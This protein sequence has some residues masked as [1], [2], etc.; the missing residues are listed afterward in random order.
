[1]RPGCGIA[2]SG[3]SALRHGRVTWP[4]PIRFRTT[5]ATCLLAET[6]ELRFLRSV[7]WTLGTHRQGHT[8]IVEGLRTEVG[9][10]A[11]LP[12]APLF[13]LITPLWNTPPR[14]LHELI[15]S[16]RCQSWL[17]WEL[18]LVDD[19]SVRCDHLD[20]AR[21]WAA[22]DP[23]IHLAMRGANGGI[24][25]ARNEAIAL[26]SGDFLAVLYHDDLLH[27]LALS[28]FVRQL[29]GRP[30][31]NLLYSN[32]AKI[33]EASDEVGF[34]LNKPPFDLSTLLR[35]NYLCHFTAV[36]R[37]LVLAVARDGLVFRPQFDGADD[38]DLFL[39]M[40][41]TGRVRPVHVPMCLYYWRMIATSTA[42]SEETKPDLDGKRQAMLA[43][44]L[45]KIYSWCRLAAPVPSAELGNQ[46]TSI[47]ITTLEA[48]PRPKLLV[49]VPF[50][51]NLRSPSAA[52]NPSRARSTGSTWR[53]S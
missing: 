35:V 25:A 27:P 6:E 47:R 1:M 52:S 11:E 7:P 43:D 41:L 48:H 39:R 53:L 13:S 50:R 38:H 28:T 51:D 34:Y 33:N 46:Y 9:R 5:S 22:R 3:W 23:R 18:I 45:P 49:M 2:T 30:D 37:D 10:L 36:R 16:V 20:V 40:A 31:V 44:L 17:H 42:Q 32:E 14:L 12:Q 29:H 4:P 24:S 26:S 21:H 15:L 19:G 8:Y